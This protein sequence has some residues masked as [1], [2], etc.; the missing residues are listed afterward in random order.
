MLLQRQMVGKP[1]ISMVVF[2]PNASFR[3]SATYF[4]LSADTKSKPL[5]EVNT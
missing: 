2:A 1:A 4:G 5:S 3:T